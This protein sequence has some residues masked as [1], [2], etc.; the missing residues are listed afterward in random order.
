MA[1]AALVQVFNAADEFPKELRRLYLTESL[2]SDDE[3]K[4]LASV[5][6][7]H[8]HEEFLLGFDDLQVRLANL[9]RKAG[10][11]WDV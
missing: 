8:D 10:S 3:V 6:V 9:P 2:V 11:R 4:E 1:D 7:L 5:G